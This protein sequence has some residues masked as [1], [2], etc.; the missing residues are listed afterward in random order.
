M[1]EGIP[2]KCWN[3]YRSLGQNSTGNLIIIP[4]EFLGWE[5]VLK[6]HVFNFTAPH[7][8]FLNW[9]ASPLTF[10]HIQTTGTTV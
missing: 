7:Y 2:I 4:K 3:Y 8:L 10:C 9:E 6:S 1:Q 5:M